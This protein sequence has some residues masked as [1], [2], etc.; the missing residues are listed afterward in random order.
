MRT[1]KE[2]KSFDF[3]Q[4]FSAQIRLVRHAQ[5]YYSKGHIKTTNCL[6][7]LKR[8]FIFLIWNRPRLLSL[9]VLMIVALYFLDIGLCL[10]TLLGY[11][12]SF[13]LTFMCL[14]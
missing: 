8:V 9:V 3:G 5:F 2:F 11:V 4:D 10:Y 7:H 1:D 13:Q 6:Y 12:I 14:L